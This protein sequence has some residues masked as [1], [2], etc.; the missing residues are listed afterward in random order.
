M[1]SPV[2]DN[3]S[4]SPGTVAPGGSFVVT[5]VAH[6]AD[7]Q[8]YTGVTEATD[9]AGNKTQASYVVKVADPLTFKNTLPSGFVSVPRAGQPGVFDCIA[10]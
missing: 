10:P 3:V 1:A 4:A 5:V 8:T 6:D 7:E 2:I 9:Q